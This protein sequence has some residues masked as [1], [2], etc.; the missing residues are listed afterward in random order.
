MLHGIKYKLNVVCLFV[1]IYILIFVANKIIF[2]KPALLMLF[3]FLMC[4]SRLFSSVTAPPGGETSSIDIIH[5]KMA[6]I[7]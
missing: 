7:E 5:I 4:S 2:R 1:F 6:S 3:L